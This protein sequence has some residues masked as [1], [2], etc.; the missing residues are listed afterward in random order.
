MINRKALAERVGKSI[1]MEEGTLYFTK[2]IERRLFFGMTVI[3]LLLGILARVGL[4]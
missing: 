1:R 2:E 3:M 4:F